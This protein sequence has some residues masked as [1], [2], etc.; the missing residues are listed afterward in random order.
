MDDDAQAFDVTQDKWREYDLL[1]Q[2]FRN[3][4]HSCQGHKPDQLPTDNHNNPPFKT[5]KC[6]MCHAYSPTCKSYLVDEVEYTSLCKECADVYRKA[7]VP[8][9]EYKI[10][11]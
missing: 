4:P 6:I 10:V 9:T 8:V 7:G 1:L 3:P 11:D 2:R 5:N